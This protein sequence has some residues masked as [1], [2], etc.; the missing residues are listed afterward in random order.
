LS[1]RSGSPRA[2]G[3]DSPDP[4]LFDPALRRFSL[5]IV[6]QTTRMFLAEHGPLVRVERDGQGWRNS[7]RSTEPYLHVHAGR[8]GLGVP[9]AFEE[10]GG[11]T[12]RRNDVLRIGAGGAR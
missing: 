10:A 1:R 7:G 2:L 3:S 5:P 6:G 4:E 12:L 11:R 8:G 9:L